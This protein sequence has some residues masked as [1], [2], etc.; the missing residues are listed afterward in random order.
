MIITEFYEETKAIKTFDS[1]A[2]IEPAQRWRA[3]VDRGGHKN[4]MCQK[5]FVRLLSYGNI[6]VLRK[7]KGG[8][9][10]VS[11]MLTFAYGG[12]R[13]HTYV[14]IVWKKR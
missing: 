4:E 13:G 5:I 6:H 7:H 14:I 9:E 8:R 2:S 11:Q 1:S 10:G 12:A 3:R